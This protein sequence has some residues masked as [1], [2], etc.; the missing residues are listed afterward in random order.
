MKNKS[1]K[2]IKLVS[3]FAVLM[4]LSSLASAGPACDQLYSLRAQENSCES[5]NSDMARD[6]N[7]MREEAEQKER[8]LAPGQIDSY[9]QSCN[10]DIGQSLAA[11]QSS[12]QA[13]SSQTDSANRA[14]ARLQQ[15]SARLEASTKG[16][17]CVG[18]DKKYVWTFRASGR[19]E[20]EA[21]AR[22][23]SPDMSQLTP[24]QISD[25]NNYLGMAKKH[26]VQI[27][28]L[29]N[30]VTANAGQGPAPR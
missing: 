13:L 28:C 17:E 11:I 30:F 5:N 14:E 20:Q 16:Y 4:S 12:Q 6:T 27:F 3:C 21:R 2:N 8:D 29:R 26:G 10:A 19:T 1:S 22:L 18:M 7:R 9:L 15:D 24:A 23:A 25:T